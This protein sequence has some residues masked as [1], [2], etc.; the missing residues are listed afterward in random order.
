MNLDAVGEINLDAV[1]VDTIPEVEGEGFTA[2]DSGAFGAKLEAEMLEI[3]S[4]NILDSVLWRKIGL[5]T[6]IK[7]L[8]ELICCGTD[9]A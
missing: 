8:T 3:K 9:S 1:D 4:V 2:L 5:N 6:C 7:L